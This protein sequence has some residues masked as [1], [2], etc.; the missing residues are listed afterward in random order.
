[1][2]KI[3]LPTLFFFCVSSAQASDNADQ[4]KTAPLKEFFFEKERK[5]IRKQ[6]NAIK[7]KRREGFEK[8]ECLLIHAIILFL[9]KNPH[10]EDTFR[11]SETF[12]EK[13]RNKREELEEA[14]KALSE[15]SSN[16]HTEKPRSDEKEKNR[17]FLNK[18]EK[19]TRKLT[20]PILQGAILQTR[21]E[22]LEAKKDMRSLSQD[23]FD[24]AKLNVKEF[25]IELTNEY[26]APLCQQA[27]EEI[28]ELWGGEKDK[29]MQEE[30]QEMIE[31][32]TEKQTK[33]IK[34]KAEQTLEGASELI[35]DCKQVL[36]NG[37]VGLIALLAAASLKGK[38]S[39]RKA[40]K[41]QEAL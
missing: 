2:K 37:S 18:M 26:T 23:F 8:R 19:N 32:I 22:L 33:K 9:Q 41:E 39:T 4:P 27:K 24:L 17:G 1:M 35:E 16:I 15:G 12:W 21:Y 20:E 14:K 30:I 40:S 6:I 7:T 38:K 29:S 5:Q 11:F 28:Q 36:K 3:L 31:K 10:W 25:F 34:E 13:I